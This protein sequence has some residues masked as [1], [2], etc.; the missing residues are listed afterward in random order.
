MF[1]LTPQICKLSN[2]PNHLPPASMNE[3]EST[4]TGNNFF[5]IYEKKSHSIII[6]NKKETETPWRETIIL[7]MKRMK[8]TK[9]LITIYRH[10]S[11]HLVPTPKG[12]TLHNKNTQLTARA[13]TKGSK[14]KLLHTEELTVTR[15][16]ISGKTSQLPINT[17]IWRTLNNVTD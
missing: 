11:P 5:S 15:R 7:P 9:K 2:M 6:N 10:L 13:H 12:T 16:H 4:P 3:Y 17:S 8:Q 1:F 14:E